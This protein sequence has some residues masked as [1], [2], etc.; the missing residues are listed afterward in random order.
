MSIVLNAAASLGVRASSPIAVFVTKLSPHQFTDIVKKAF[1]LIQWSFL[2]LYGTKEIL[3]DRV[4]DF[5]K[6]KKNGFFPRPAEKNDYLN[7]IFVKKDPFLNKIPFNIAHGS[8]YISA[9]VSG[10]LA[11]ISNNGWINNSGLNALMPVGQSLFGLACLVALIHN[12]KIY[13][14][15]A[16]IPAFA[17]LHQREAANML[18]KSAIF[19]I[20]SSL[21]YLLAAAM[22]LMGAPA[23]LALVFGC[24]AVFTGCL[25]IIYDF[26]RFRGAR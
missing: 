18:K 2:S 4:K 9:G 22:M 6:I 16:K 12:V 26:I 7:R 17:P 19:G 10:S 8:L 11:A 24:V 21:N 13:R 3:F 1:S 5:N 25:K 23:A 20:I 14:A 15:A